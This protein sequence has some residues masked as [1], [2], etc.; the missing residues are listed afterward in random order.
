MRKLSGGC[1][2]EAAPKPKEKCPS[3]IKLMAFL[4]DR[5]SSH[6]IRQGA[7]KDVT[8]K[9]GDEKGNGEC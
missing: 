7:E 9:L 2:L 5:E 4:N 3:T 8:T 1:G 6:N